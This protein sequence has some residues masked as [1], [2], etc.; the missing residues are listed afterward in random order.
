MNLSK[1][2][3]LRCCF[4]APLLLPHI[5]IFLF[6]GKKE[7]ILSDLNRYSRYRQ[8]GIEVHF[9]NGSLQGVQELVLLPCR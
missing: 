6:S 2:Q 7:V 3:I 9:R 8:P 5:F 4:W 1:G